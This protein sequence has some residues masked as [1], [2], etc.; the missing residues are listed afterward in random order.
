VSSRIIT[1]DG[2]TVHLTHWGAFEAVS[3]GE[4]L[5]EVRPWRGDPEPMPLIG[6]VASAQHHPARIAVP[7]VRKGWLDHGPGAS[8][9]GSDPFVPVTWDM[10]L[11]LLAG[12]LRRV[13]R[14]HGAE[15]VYG[16]SYGWASAGRFH[17]AQSQVH[18]FLNCLG[19]YVRHVNS[20]SL[21]TST[22]LL[23]HVIAD[24][25]VLLNQAT[26]KS[27]VAE[28]SELVVAFG[29]LSP[30]NAAVSPGGVSRHNARSWV[31]A[32]R[33]RGC[34]F[35]SVS[36][37]RDDTPAEAQAEWI[38]PRPGT[39]AALM[40]ALAQVLDADGLAETGF[41]D[42]YTVG[43]LRFARYLRGEADGVVKNPPWA[44]EITGVPAARI[45]ELAHEMAAA[46]TLVTVSWSLQRARHGEQ[47]L[48]LGVVLAAMLG[49]IGLPGG[50]FG[51]GYGSA[52][53]V[54]EPAAQ[55]S[56][57]RLPQG[58]NAVA[59]FIP[60]ARI[61]DMLLN[62]GAAYDYNGQRLTYPDIRLVYWC[63]GN[64]F[65][66]HQDLARLREAF[67]RPDTVVVHDPFWTA[68]ARHADIVLPVTMSIERDD[69]GCGQ[70]DRM[71]FPMPSLT[72]P[73]GEARDDYSIFA[74][75]AER[76][77]TGKDFT[78]GRTA[79]DWLRHLYEQWRGN[80]AERGRAVPGF[81]EF[82]ASDGL[83]LP[84]ASEPQVA[85]ADFRANPEG[86]PLTTPT[87]KIEIF[88]AT[89]DS[90][91]Y[92]DCPGHPVWLE[93]DEWL[94]SP[95]AG[96]LGLQLVAN[97]PRSRLHSQL[98]VGAH[99]QSVKIAGREPVRMHP[100]DAAVR[101]LRDGELVRIF[102]DRGACLAGLA[103]DEAVRPGVAQLSTGAWYDPDPALPGFC[104]HGN[105]NV[106]TADRPSSTLSQ[107]CTGQLTLV[108]IE[109]YRGTPPE[110]SVTRPPATT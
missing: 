104:R 56:V 92:P 9:R 32:A 105:P 20:Y 39:D 106:L 16:G 51:H 27:V 41:L 109:P 8:G 25:N 77:G 5:T 18:R 6:N 86:H 66:H 45:R 21:G 26:A 85:F 12:E 13:Y 17:H 97:Q 33:A 37:L 11:N 75:L 102:N 83:E 87:G 48:W 46:R 65:H 7:H 99:S 10:A 24:V 59:T 64:P 53:L 60:V 36:P 101:G 76:L 34:R 88:S 71:F 43:Y 70:N 3:D 73:H 15:A 31:S 49:Q 103:T 22:V 52:S 58:R 63:G 74:E 38:A 28:H 30:K 55:V 96:R 47:P 69:Y 98:D 4:R 108:E 61:A 67:A 72:R 19:G 40:L 79:M 100:S 1:I 107:G 95:A 44:E 2:V 14:D 93:P 80:L 82:W 35:V 81:D 90:F 62:P 110:L 42:R 84:V 54:G 91:G 57:P 94:G 78:E 89:I 29:G 50:G 23:P 68:T